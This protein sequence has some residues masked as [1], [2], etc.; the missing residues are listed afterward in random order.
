[1]AENNAK[2][3]TTDGLRADKKTLPNGRPTADAALE[4]AHHNS[5]PSLLRPKTLSDYV[6]QTEIK[7]NLGVFIQAAKNRNDSL[8]HVLLSGPPGL[9]KTT[10]AHIVAHEMQAPL[11]ITAGPVLERQGDLAA[12]LT[13]L[14]AGELLFIDEI[15]R[16]SRHVE[17]VLYSAM[18]DWQLDVI[19][20]QGPMARS[21]RVPLLPFTLVGATTRT[22]L[23]SA[24]LR[25]RFG[26]P[27]RLEYYHAKEL[28][29]VLLR[30]AKR[31]GI[32]MEEPAALELGKRSRGTPRT[33]NRLLKRVIDYAQHQQRTII[34]LEI[35]HYSLQQLGIDAYGLDPFD[36]GFLTALVHTFD[37]QPV[38]LSTLAAALSESKDAIEEVYEPFLIKEGFVHKTPRGRMA[39]AK[40]YAHLN[41]PMLVGDQLELV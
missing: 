38:G 28:A 29:E 26:I 13:G 27:I 37:G 40:A 2:A 24:P 15:H 41:A 22:G 4:D 19:V 33:A 9:G 23:L 21:V 31:L 5:Q 14:Q 10:L 25:E 1:M 18:E 32:A 12:I 16:L 36:M 35:V 11:R 6:G 3:G 20:G 34:S 8:D 30:S 7:S 39:T 17:E